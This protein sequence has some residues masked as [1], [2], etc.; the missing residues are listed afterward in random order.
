MVDKESQGRQCLGRRGSCCVWIPINRVNKYTRY[1][2]FLEAL[3]Y[4][5]GSA[6]CVLH[7]SWKCTDEEPE[8]TL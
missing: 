1:P 8:H 2:A 7:Y 6:L 3:E 5:K 4:W